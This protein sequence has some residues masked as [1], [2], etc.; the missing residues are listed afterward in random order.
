M[1]YNLVTSDG[2]PLS[3]HWVSFA[4]LPDG[5]MYHPAFQGYSGNEIV[6]R[7]GFELDA[8]REVCAKAGG[9]FVEIGSASFVFRALPCVPLLANYWLGDEDFPSSCRILIDE[10][11]C[12][13][14]PI[15]ACAILGS[16]LA[17]KLIRS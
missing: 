2:T 3:E 17:Q 10:Y 9:K 6:K 8:F 16:M 7:F 5:R 15:D 11:A 13:Y 4:D 1:L 14:L 12:H